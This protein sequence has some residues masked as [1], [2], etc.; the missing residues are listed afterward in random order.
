MG[1]AGVRR[2]YKEVGGRQIFYTLQWILTARRVL[3]VHQ[4][5]WHGGCTQWYLGQLVTANYLR[6]ERYQRRF[7]DPKASSVIL[8]HR[9]FLKVYYRSPM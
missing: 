5:Y 9:A 4:D 2:D 6:L 8:F 1:H 7:Q 3:C